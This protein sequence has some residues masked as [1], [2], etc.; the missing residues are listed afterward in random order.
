[1]VNTLKVFIEE[2]KP[3]GAR[4]VGA[5]G[6]AMTLEKMETSEIKFQ[7]FSKIFNGKENLAYLFEERFYEFVFTVSKN[8]KENF[9]KSLKNYCEKNRFKFHLIGFTKK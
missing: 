9:E 1:M 8:Q 3:Q 7:P 2:T 6:L 5:G 4:I